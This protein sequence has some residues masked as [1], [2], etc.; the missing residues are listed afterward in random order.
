MTFPN[1]TDDRSRSSYY[2]EPPAPN[3]MFN[4]NLQEFSQRVGLICTLEANGQ[5]A[6]EEAYRQ[7]K[8]LWKALKASKRELFERNG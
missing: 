8:N 5:I 7:I 2:G 4:A 6:S 3:L 1:S